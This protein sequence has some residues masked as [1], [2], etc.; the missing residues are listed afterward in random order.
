MTNHTL[1]KVIHNLVK[2]YI[3]RDHLNVII[4]HRQHICPVWLAIYIL[5]GANCAPLHA[6]L[7]ISAYVA[8]FL[9]GFLW[10]KDIK[11]AH[12]FNT[13]IRYVN[14][15]LLLNSS[16]LGNYLHL[17]YPNKLEVKD[18]T[19]TLMS[20]SDLDLHLEIDRQRKKF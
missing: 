12:A 16:W 6:H 8:D 20:A 17:I 14:D 18:T 2:I 19:D 15:V 9:P 3:G 4:F 10:N 7:F 13:S 11:L 5:M 1:S